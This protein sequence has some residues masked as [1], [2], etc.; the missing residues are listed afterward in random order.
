M[1]R[2]IENQK[3]PAADPDS[4]G[5]LAQKRTGRAKTRLQD[6]SLNTKDWAKQMSL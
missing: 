4:S 5:E 1:E 3:S 6:G 2:L